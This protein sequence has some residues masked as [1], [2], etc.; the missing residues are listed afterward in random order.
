M[1]V[2]NCSRLL[3]AISELLKLGASTTLRSRVGSPSLFTAI[4]CDQAEVN[5]ILYH[6]GADLYHSEIGLN[7]FPKMVSGLLQ[8]KKDP[9]SAAVTIV[10][11]N[12]QLSQCIQFGKFSPKNEKAIIG[13]S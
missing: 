3:E 5:E 9:E 12:S 6:H 10:A 13:C 2:A 1:H 4:G 8:F 11:S 7:T